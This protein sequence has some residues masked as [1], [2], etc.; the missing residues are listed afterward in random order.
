MRERSLLSLG[1]HEFHRIAYTEW[2]DADNPRTL[3]CVHGL[4]GNGRYFDTLARA[5]ERDYRVVCP[6][7]VGR[8][9]SEWLSVK[10]DYGYPV[11]CSDMAA[12][13]ARL[14]VEQ[15]DWLGTSMGGLIGMVLAAR[16]GAPIRKLVL[17]DVGPFIAKAALE[18]I[19]AYV[20]K[21]P[22]FET[23][24]QAE[25]YMRETYASFGE[26]S[27]SQWRHLTRF[28]MRQRPEGG[29]TLAYDPG[30]AEPF[31]A[32][33]ED[34]DLWPVWDAVHAP[35]LLL[36]GA[37][38]DVLLRE[39]AEEMCRRGPATR[40]VEFAGV[41]H[42]PALMDGEQIERVRHWLAAD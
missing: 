16:P 24:E 30:I 1:P 40:L 11:Y 38:S 41:G 25:R 3:L 8:G 17:N 27:D 13:I 10:G 20:G 31:A 14:D 32:A 2:G 9:R 6:D 33:L 18:R 34:V 19:A 35:V 39:T 37:D 23:W 15:V 42:A 22:S 26:L 7:V 4:T 36:R 29:Y 21:Q 5:L 12:L 28:N